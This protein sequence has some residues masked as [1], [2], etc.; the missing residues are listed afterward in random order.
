MDLL[1]VLFIGELFS[2][3]NLALKIF[4][5]LAVVSFVL[6]HLGKA[7]LSYAL[8]GGISW[9]V[10]F[11][12]WMFFGGV[13]VLYTMMTLGVTGVLVDFFFVSQMSGEG[14]GGVSPV[15]SAQDLA[16]RQ[17]QLQRA[18]Q[19]MARMGGNA[20]ASKKP[21]GGGAPGGAGGPGGGMAMHKP[22]AHMKRPGG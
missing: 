5:L 11:D 13:F 20:V 22:G 21:G 6:S 19:A 8:I 14:G 1:S 18:N 10:L 16:M 9:F 12:Y 7:P 2:D 3:L 4:A 17:K 15:D